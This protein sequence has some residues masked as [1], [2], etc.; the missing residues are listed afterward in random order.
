MPR[1]ATGQTPK[2]NI[3]VEDEI[4]LPAS[5]RAEQEGRSVASVVRDYLATYGAQF[6]PDAVSADPWDVVNLVVREITSGRVGPSTDLPTAVEAAV[7]MLRALG[8]TPVS[9]T[10][11]ANGA[12]AGE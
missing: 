3:R 4:W 11:S 9:D 2:R 12:G 7:T 5:A 8:I 10:T 6:R 1:P